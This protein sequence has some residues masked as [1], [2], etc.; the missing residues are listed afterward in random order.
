TELVEQRTL[1][2][3][4]RSHHQQLSCKSRELNQQP[5]HRSSRVF[6]QYPDEAVFWRRHLLDRF[7]RIATGNLPLQ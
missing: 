7:A 4:P 1:R 6:Q 2:N 3:L 5:K